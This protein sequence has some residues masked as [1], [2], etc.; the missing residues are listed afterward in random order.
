VASIQLEAVTSKATR[1]RETLPTASLVWDPYENP[2]T[3]K[4]DS[5]LSK[6]WNSELKKKENYTCD[7]SKRGVEGSPGA[8]GCGSYG[9]RLADCTNYANH[10]LS[11]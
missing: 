8:L 4:F 5:C 1:L 9:E 10:L 2:I 3:W 6:N 7:P 11:N